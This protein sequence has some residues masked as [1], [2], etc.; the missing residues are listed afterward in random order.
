GPPTAAVIANSAGG[1][2]GLGIAIAMIH[3]ASPRFGSAIGL[4][5]ALAICVSWNLGLW[6]WSRRKL[7]H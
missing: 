2:M 3:V 5:N 4:G 6:W 7:I 1:L